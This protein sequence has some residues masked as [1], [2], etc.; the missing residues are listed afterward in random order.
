MKTLFKLP[1]LLLALM[2]IISSC[3]KIASPKYDVKKLV[4]IDEKLKNI[5]DFSGDEGKI[6][7]EEYV[8]IIEKY[9]ESREKWKKFKNEME[10]YDEFSETNTDYDNMRETVELIKKYFPVEDEESVVLEEI[11]VEDKVIGIE[12]E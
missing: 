2:L 10:K 1:V 6:V 3:D 12:K 5:N 8:E 11:V 7:L 9:L 4:K